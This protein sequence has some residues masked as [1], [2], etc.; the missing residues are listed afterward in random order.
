[1]EQNKKDLKKNLNPKVIEL[2]EDL[3]PQSK[4]YLFINH[5]QKR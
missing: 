1:M 4:K 3:V 5:I 2:S